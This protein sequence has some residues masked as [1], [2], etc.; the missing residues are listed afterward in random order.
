MRSTHFIVT[1]VFDDETLAF[2]SDSLR[3]FDSP[4]PHQAGDADVANQLHALTSKI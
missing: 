2:L 3:S 1:V 4:S